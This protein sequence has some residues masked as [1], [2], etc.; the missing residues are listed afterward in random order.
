MIDRSN[1]CVVYYDDAYI[2]P[3]SNKSCIGLTGYQPKSGTKLAYDYALKNNIKI[4]NVL[5]NVQKNNF[6][7]DK[8]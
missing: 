5:D 8:R 3:K 1:F 6:S 2:P 7:C 4:I